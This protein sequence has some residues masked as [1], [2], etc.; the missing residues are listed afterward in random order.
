MDGLQLL[1]QLQMVQKHLADLQVKWYSALND[2]MWHK[3]FSSTQDSQALL[4]IQV[5]RKEEEIAVLKKKGE[6]EK[7]AIG[8]TGKWMLCRAKLVS[9]TKTFVMLY[10]YSYPYFPPIYY[11]QTKHFLVMWPTAQLKTTVMIKP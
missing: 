1:E 2:N 7:L 10:L 5:T 11:T 3:I 4:R 8:Y 9:L 6:Q